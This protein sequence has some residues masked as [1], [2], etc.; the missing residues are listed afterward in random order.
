MGTI[1]SYTHGCVSRP[2]SA[3][4]NK[5][6]QLSIA[7]NGSSQLLIS[8]TVANLKTGKVKEGATMGVVWRRPTAV[9]IPTVRKTTGNFL[10]HKRHTSTTSFFVAYYV[11][12]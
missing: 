11:A 9:A 12:T 8:T 5:I 2:A 4:R 3:L 6:I 1:A 7:V 10:K